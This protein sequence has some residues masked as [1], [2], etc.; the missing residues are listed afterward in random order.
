[1][2]TTKTPAIFRCGDG[3]GSGT[4]EVADLSVKDRLFRAM[5]RAGAVFLVGCISIII[6]VLHFILFPLFFILSIALFFFFFSQ[7]KLVLSGAAT[8]PKCS[9]TIKI[10]QQQL[11]L[12]L[13]D[14]CE[15]CHRRVEVSL[16][17]FE[18]CSSPHSS[19]EI[20]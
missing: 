10:F 7:K 6:P 2:K 12:P 18:N 8:C 15:G 13:I 20:K 5:V 11:T 4:L 9:S 14:V 19:T 17:S 16:A 3:E 1:M